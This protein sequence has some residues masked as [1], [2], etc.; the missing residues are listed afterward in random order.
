MP[1]LAKK[2]VDIRR[3]YLPST[4]DLPQDQQAWV[5]LQV[6]KMT[7]E[8]MLVLDEEDTEHDAQATA[9]VLSNRIKAWNFTE[10][11]G[12]DI[13]ISYEA[14]CR[15]DP[16]DYMEIAKSMQG[17]EAATIPKANGSN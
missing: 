7:T 5:E 6:G 3:V 10:E 15:L 12:T 17:T 13:E 8:D 4:K 9:K 1:N 16:V 14:V 11:D 2:T